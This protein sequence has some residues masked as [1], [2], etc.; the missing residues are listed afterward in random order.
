MQKLADN[1]VARLTR[2]ETNRLSFGKTPEQP[3]ARLWG[4]TGRVYDC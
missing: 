1:T 3:C 2:L 4:N